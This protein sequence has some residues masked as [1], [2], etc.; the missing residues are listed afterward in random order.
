[1]DYILEMEDIQIEGFSEEKWIPII[2]GISLHL[3]KGLA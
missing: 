2:K 3:E 1:M